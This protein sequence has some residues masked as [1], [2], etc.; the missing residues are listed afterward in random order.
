MEITEAFDEDVVD[1]S[2]TDC[3]HPKVEIPDPIGP[4]G[5]RVRV[6]AAVA[7]LAVAMWDEGPTFACGEQTGDEDEAV[8]HFA[9]RAD[10]AEF[11]AELG[12]F[13]RSGNFQVYYKPDHIRIFFPL[14]WVGG[15][16]GRYRRKWARWVEEAR[17][18]L[19]TTPRERRQPHPTVTLDGIEIDEELAPL[20]RKLWDA[21]VKTSSCCQEGEPGV[22]WIQFPSPAEALRFFIPASSLVGSC[23]WI[24]DDAHEIGADFEAN[25]IGRVSIEFPREDLGALTRLWGPGAGGGG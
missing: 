1:M 9:D 15:L 7:P 12:D 24:V 18:T 5:S 6:D 25:T 19:D 3:D 8:L 10:A 20:I 22:A 17:A 4:P 23:G 2:C 14:H 21:G 11:I 13:G 16:A